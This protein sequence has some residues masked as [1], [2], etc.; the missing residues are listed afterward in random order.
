VTPRAWRVLALV[1]YAALTLLHLAWHLW[2]APPARLPLAFVL[3]LALG[4]LAMA[5]LT[6]MVDL[7]R[8]LFW[9]GFAALMYFSHGVMEAWTSPEVRML[10]HAEWLLSTVLVIAVGA[11]GLAERRTARAARRA[12]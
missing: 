4:P 3:V 10:A 1:A 6:M 7:R 11:A 12:A 2:L 9:A 8:G 5:G